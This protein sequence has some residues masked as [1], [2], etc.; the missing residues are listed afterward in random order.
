MFLQT[1]INEAYFSGLYD[2]LS[3]KLDIFAGYYRYEMINLIN[4][5]P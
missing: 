5:I 1:F 3:K 4:G 2:F